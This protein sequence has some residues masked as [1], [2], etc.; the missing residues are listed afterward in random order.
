MNTQHEPRTE[1][2]DDSDYG[3]D[4]DSEGEQLLKDVLARLEAGKVKPSQLDHN[5]NNAS[6]EPRPLPR[7][8]RHPVAVFQVETSP[9]GCAEGRSS[10]LV[11][12]DN[13]ERLVA[14]D[15]ETSERANSEAVP[16]EPAIAAEPPLDERS[17]LERFRTLPKKPLSVTDI[18]SPAWCELQYWYTLTKHGRKRRT[19]AMKEGSRVHK[20]LEEQVHTTVEV[21]VKTREDAWGLK[22][23]NIIQGL[24]TLK[25]LGFTRELEVWGVVDGQIVNGIIDELSYTRP[26]TRRRRKPKSSSPEPKDL[27]AT[28]SDSKQVYITDVKTRGSK[29][30]PSGS[31]LRPTEMQLML[32]RKLLMNLATN[33]VDAET[34]LERYRLKPHEQFTD[35]FVA[36]VA[37]LDF[38]FSDESPDEDT[39]MMN[40]QDDSL[41]ELVAHNTLA[42][43]WQLMIQEFLQAMPGPDAVSGLLRAEFRDQKTGDFLGNKFF[44]Y[45]EDVVGRYL[46]DE[47]S[48]WRGER[49]AKGVD[50]EEAFKCRFCDFA[51]SC[52]W[53]KNKVDEAVAKFRQKF[54][55]KEQ[56]AAAA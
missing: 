56:E 41:S 11:H 45:D 17:P 12:R 37:Q 1:P 24:R 32:Y 19:P 44:D 7:P 8:I 30:L 36:E 31:S 55:P 34:V 4:L 20:T 47:M 42:K 38:N 15:P 21:L 3:S 29:T 46:A 35:A 23:W 26:D 13:D 48:W 14:R 39:A 5:V 43:L 10:P 52:D 6:P 9:A 54:P 2:A 16:V 50:I 53:R 33:Q 25:N 28:S 51:E 27:A 49:G 40:S 18:V 22:I